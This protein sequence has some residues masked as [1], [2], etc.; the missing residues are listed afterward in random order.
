MNHSALADKVLV[1]QVL[2]PQSSTG[3]INSSGVDMSGWDGVQFVIAH[4]VFGT[5]GTL[6]AYVQ[7]DDNSGFNS[8]TNIANAA[9]AAIVNSNGVAI[10]DVYRP[11]ER[12]V[13]IAV[14]GQ[15]NGVQVGVTA[16]RYR[17]NGILP[18]TQ[19]AVQVVRIVEN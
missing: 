14:T 17:R 5:N 2:P 4:G 12:Y 13:R 11:S 9:L 18:P 10:I 6:N 15:T 8:P 16:H 7:R 3:L 1:S 19:A